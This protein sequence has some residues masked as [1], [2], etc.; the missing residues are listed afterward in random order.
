MVS[1]PRR[2]QASRA[3]VPGNMVYKRVSLS[4]ESLKDGSR[5]I[6]YM[7]KSNGVLVL[8]TADCNNIYMW[9]TQWI[10]QICFVSSANNDLQLT[11]TEQRPGH[12][13]R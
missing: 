8:Q 3:R 4:E 13:L 11:Q 9:E 7:C 2:W 6:V 10:S 5:T 12:C 1:V